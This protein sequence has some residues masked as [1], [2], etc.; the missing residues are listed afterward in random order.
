[1]PHFSTPSSRWA[2]VQAR[3]P[4]A[5]SAFIYSVITTKIY[6]RPTCP[7]RLARRA[8]VTFHNS[9]VEAEADGFRACKRCRPELAQV[10]A[11]PQRVFVDKAC[12]LIGMEGG[13]GEKWSVKGLAKEVGLTESHFCRVFKK[14]LGI[15]VGEYRARIHLE[16]PE[17][18]SKASAVFPL[19][20][21][22]AGSA[23][24]DIFIAGLDAESWDLPM[25][26][27]SFDPNQIWLSSTL[28]TT[29]GV[30]LN[31]KSSGLDPIG[32]EMSENLPLEGCWD[33]P[34]DHAWEDIDQFINY[35]S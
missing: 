19:T 11:D 4:L 30:Y 15:T 34:N 29:G 23:V 2:A 20:A 18:S 8:N 13:G 24:P 21:H 3:N 12:E 16:P 5:A 27:F 6:C 14:V 17:I 26:E 25:N 9:A 10:A 33:R 31:D 7:S 28:C 1:M 32:F 35:D 22:G